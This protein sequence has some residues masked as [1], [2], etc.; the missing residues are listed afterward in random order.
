MDVGDREEVKKIDA[1]FL[2]RIGA[3]YRILF[4]PPTEEELLT[5]FAHYLKKV[6]VEYKEN[7]GLRLAI[8]PMLLNMP[9]DIT[10]LLPHLK[11]LRVP[12]QVESWTRTAIEQIVEGEERA[13]KRKLRISDYHLTGLL[14]EERKQ[15][16]ERWE[17]ISQMQAVA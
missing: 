7:F 1:A 12:R 4:S 8:D 13:G 3:A 14:E 16:E 2:N 9:E 15:R 17:R 10:G 6:R 5:I 11:H